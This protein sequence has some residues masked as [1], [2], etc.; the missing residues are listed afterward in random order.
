[1][2]DGLDGVVSVDGYDDAWCARR[3]D[4]AVLCWKELGKPEPIGGVAHARQ[5]SNGCALLDDGTVRCWDESGAIRDLGLKGA[6]RLSRGR[7]GTCAILDTGRILCWGT[8]ATAY[9]DGPPGQSETPTAIQ[10]I[11][12]VDEI[13]LSALRGACARKGGRISC[14]GGEFNEPV[15]DIGLNDAVELSSGD[16]HFCARR[17]DGTVACWGENATGELGVEQA[18]LERSA[19][20]VPIS[21]VRDAIHVASGGGEP[22]GGAGASCVIR[23]DGTVFCWGATDSTVDPTHVH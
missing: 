13:Q 2:I 8:S 16:Y 12:E 17:R 7:G 14:W 21:G 11:R 15:H 23:K 22:T 1:V 3:G 18:K 20:P 6:Q 10:R 9:L 5:V 19:T 4:G